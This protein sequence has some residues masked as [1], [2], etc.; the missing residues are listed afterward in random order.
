MKNVSGIGKAIV[1]VVDL[2]RM[3][4]LISVRLSLSNIRTV[5]I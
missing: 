5:V 4:F 2:K 1:L 3:N